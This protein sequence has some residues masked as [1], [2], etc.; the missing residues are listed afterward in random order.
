[1]K[2]MEK[3]IEE[4]FPKARE[5]MEEENAFWE[6]YARLC[7]AENHLYE[8]EDRLRKVNVAIAMSKREDDEAKKLLKVAY[9]EFQRA[10]SD[11]QL[12]KRV[13]NFARKRLFSIPELVKKAK[14]DLWWAKH[15]FYRAE[16]ARCESEFLMINLEMRLA[17]NKARKEVLLTQVESVHEKWNL[18]KQV[19]DDMKSRYDQMVYN[20]FDP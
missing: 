1:M 8:A 13:V 17:D 11:Y 20:T 15:C 6:A 16:C 2:E 12:A 3:C 4:A 10:S 7:D 5:Y 19:R 14:Q 18:A 9:D